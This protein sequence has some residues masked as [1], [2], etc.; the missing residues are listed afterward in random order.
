MWGDT[1]EINAQPDEH[2]CFSHWE[3]VTGGIALDDPNSMQTSFNM[4]KN[5]VVIKAYIEKEDYLVLIAEDPNGT[6]TGSGIY[7]WDT[8]VQIS[9]MPN[10]GYYFKKW[11]I[12]TGQNVLWNAALMETGFIMPKSN[13]ILQAV[14][15]KI[16]C[17]I[18]IQSD[19]SG[20]E[21]GGGTYGWGSSVT[22][23]ARPKEGLRFVCWKKDGQILSYDHDYTF[24]IKTSSTIQ[25]VYA[26]VGVP[27]LNIV[28]S[29]GFDSIRISWDA[30]EGASGYT[31]CCATA[32]TGVYRETENVEGKTE[33]IMNGLTMAKPYYFR[34]KAYCKTG[35]TTTYGSQSAYRFALPM[36]A[37]PPS[38]Q[39]VISGKKIKLNWGAVEKATKYELYRATVPNGKYKRLA[40][41][42][43]ISYT[44]KW[45][46]GKTYY[47]KV[48]AY[49]KK[50]RKT[51]YYGGY[52]FV[53]IKP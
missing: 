1:V 21:K 49:Y 41:T 14:F 30:V 6:V 39:A 51:Y 7:P 36:P 48:R 43:K 35:N 8:F 3:V 19:G 40:N 44:D 11:S 20:T 53:T 23:T 22:L 4:P 42:I 16:Q 34:V 31:V 46:K 27:V 15:E 17:S 28:E 13:I 12:L 24:I 5:D 50:N 25:A 10:P 18:D 32:A 9:A 33:Y 45:S 29:A 2:Y 52:A 26:P 47:Y 37:A 38:F